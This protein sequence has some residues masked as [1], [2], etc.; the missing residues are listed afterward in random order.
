MS[1]QFHTYTDGSFAIHAYGYPQRGF[2]DRDVLVTVRTLR[3]LGVRRL[4]K[5]IDHVACAVVD[6]AL[7]FSVVA[8]SYKGN[9]ARLISCYEEATARVKEI[10]SEVAVQFALTEAWMELGFNTDLKMAFPGK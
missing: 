6:D 1:T 4:I 5:M 3:D 7:I 8:Q 2:S 10:E 9:G